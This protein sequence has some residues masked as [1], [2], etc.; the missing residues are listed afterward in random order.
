MQDP[1]MTPRSLTVA[2]TNHVMGAMAVSHLPKNDDGKSGDGGGV[3]VNGLLL[4]LRRRWLLAGCL[5][6]L[7]A[8]LAVLGVL[9]VMPAQYVATSRI[10]V[11]FRTPDKFLS[12]ASYHEPDFVIY[13]AQLAAEI[14][15]RAVISN[16]MPDIKDLNMIRSVDRPIDAL[17]ASIKTDYLEAPTIL[18]VSLG[19]DN[20]EDV[21]KVVNAITNS[22]LSRKNSE[23]R[24]QYLARLQKLTDKYEAVKQALS[25][26]Q[27]RL[28]N[29]ESSHNIE[30]EVSQ[31]SKYQAALAAVATIKKAA[32]DTHLLELKS[33]EELNSMIAAEKTLDSAPVPSSIIEERL[34]Q[35]PRGQ[36]LYKNL[37]LI[38]SAIINLRT[39]VLPPL[40]DSMVAQEEAKRAAALKAIAT[41]REQIRPE[42]ERVVREK[43]SD[44]VR[45]NLMKIREDIASLQKQKSVL[46][47]A[48]T[49]AEAEALQYANRKMPQDVIALRDD[50]S[51]TKNALTDMEKTILALQIEPTQEARVSLLQPAEV[52]QMRDRSRQMKIGVVAAFGIF[53]L[54]LFGVSWLEFSTRKINAANEVVR[55]L[56][57][58]LVG[59]LP[60]IPA[61]ARKP[62]N[63][64]TTAR[65]TLLRNQLSESVDAIRTMLLHSARTEPLRVIMITS[66]EGGEG[67]TS[68]ASQLAASLARAWRKTLLIDG[69]LRNP[70]VHKLFE[71]PQEPGFSEVLR[72]EVTVADAARPS[73]ISR[74]WVMPAGHWDTHAVQALAQDGVAA[75]FKQMKEEFDFIVVDSS[76]VLPVNDSLMLGQHVDGVIFSILREV[77]RIPTVQSAHSKLMNLGVRTLGAVVIGEQ[78]SSANSAYQHAGQM[79]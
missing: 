46:S 37:S 6:I 72:G 22:F 71:A 44:D 19:G 66:A 51:N 15:G 2:D 75:L 36:E 34:I 38:D 1:K 50:I 21:T 13:K 14:K 18:K 8:W 40:R 62:I 33:Q 73:T 30:D 58:N 43:M 41:V 65:L 24:L 59:T 52:P 29:L 10:Q 57:M 7:G 48:V 54:M 68:V 69:D 5:A 64:K 78:T 77:S 26:K 27:A 20:P 53:G 35:D 76:P 61:Q 32:L 9:Q 70:Q 74:L 79:G 55:G 56:G 47:E 60:S 42:I 3:N 17:E 39:S 12:Q 31:V 63:G 67:K 28:R 45:L 49:R 23:E 4:A 11:V 25:E 16:A